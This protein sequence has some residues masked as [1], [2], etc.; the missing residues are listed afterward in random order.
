[1]TIVSNEKKKGNLPPKLTFIHKST[2]GMYMRTCIYVM[3]LYPFI[4]FI[5]K[6]YTCKRIDKPKMGRNCFTPSTTT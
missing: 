3:K 2:I 1:L 6:K 4:W 5:G